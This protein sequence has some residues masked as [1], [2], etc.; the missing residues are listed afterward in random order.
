VIW[1]NDVS[2]WD[3]DLSLTYI[4][5]MMNDVCHCC[6]NNEFILY[7]PTHGFIKDMQGVIGFEGKSFVHKY[8]K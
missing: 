2:G 6:Y 5:I 1:D 3:V 8:A 7:V 4:Y